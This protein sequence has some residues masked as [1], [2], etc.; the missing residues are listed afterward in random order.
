MTKLGYLPSAYENLEGTR[1]GPMGHMRDTMEIA[2]YHNREGKP[3]LGWVTKTGIEYYSRSSVRSLKAIKSYLPDYLEKKPLTGLFLDVTPAFLMEDYHP[4]HTFNRETDMQYKNQMEDY[5]GK[6]LG[7]VVGGEHGKAWSVAHLDYSEGPMTGSFFWEDGNKP[8]Y[9]E[10]P[11][12]TN[13]MPSD[14]KKYGWN[15]KKRIP[16]WQLVFNDAVSS[17]W[18]WGDS[19]D[20]FY[21]IDPKISDMKDNY[22]LLYGTMPLMWADEKGYGWN[23]N[24]SRFIQTIRNVSNFQE[25]IASSELLTHQFLNGDSTLQYSKFKN[26]AEVYVSFADQPISW[27]INKK[28]VNLAPR[29]FYVTAPGFKQ[30]KTFDKAGIVT[31]IVSDILISVTTNSYQKIGTITTKGKITVFKIA[32]NHWRIIAETPNS[33]S[34]INLKELLRTK[35]LKPYTLALLNENGRK[36]KTLLKNSVINE[37]NIS[38]DGGIRIFDLNW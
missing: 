23:R 2:A 16:L 34:V 21:S 31:S 30:T 13:Y 17:T 4:L 6:D 9:L 10:V 15:Y 14:F 33:T 32:D 38:G 19:S 35:K 37:L 11:K 1:E 26:G 24:R 8:G 5:V 36:I 27:K 12:D 28:T 20:W 29:G 22:N 7:L 25:R 18:Y 3:I